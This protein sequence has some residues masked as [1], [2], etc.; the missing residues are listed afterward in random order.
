MQILNI[1]I[2]SKAIKCLL[3]FDTL[4]PL[5]NISFTTKS[6][7]YFSGLLIYWKIKFLLI[8]KKYYVSTIPYSYIYNI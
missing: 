8:Y 5:Q 7:Y 4:K 1:S 6:N 2:L 3:L